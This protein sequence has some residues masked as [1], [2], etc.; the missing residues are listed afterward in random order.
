MKPR[1]LQIALWTLTTTLL[2]I[3]H[4][5]QSQT[6]FFIYQKSGHYGIAPW[7]RYNK[8]DGGFAGLS[9]V[10]FLNDDFR[11]LARVG[12]A[13]SLH[14]LRYQTGVE[15]IFPG[16]TT[17]WFI[18]ADYFHLSQTNDIQVIPDWQNSITAA[19]ARLDYYDYYDLHG[20]QVRIGM[21]RN[22]SIK[23]SLNAGYHRYET[24]KT[25]TQKSLVDW[26]GTKINGRRL[27]PPNPAVLK[28]EDVWMG[29]SLDY[30]P[31]PSPNAFINAWLV[32]ADYRFSEGIRRLA[33]TDFAY[34]QLQVDL[35]RQQRLFGK[36]RF[37]AQFRF[38]SY[39]GPIVFSDPVTHQVLPMTMFLYDVGGINTL[40]G[41]RYKEFRDG[42]RLWLVKLD[43]AFNGDFFPKTP[44]ARCW[45]LGWLFRK[46]DLAFFAD[47]GQLGYA[48]RKAFL[49]NPDGLS[50][51]QIH[52][53]A[54]V[55]VTMLPWIRMEL[56]FPLNPSESERRKQ[57]AFYFIFQLNI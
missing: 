22:G 25:E 52:Y 12:Y 15:K 13:F 36:Q 28:G 4:G 34:Q 18:M 43:Y 53:S 26:G 16:E 39:R 49:L 31:L 50:L 24:L 56:A 44:F 33:K 40:R 37:T 51:N 57:P 5:V 10:Y 41:Y 14:R 42:N 47:A 17:D 27:F 55:A 19:F 9:G 30:N 1:F 32:R 23:T 48:G 21:H 6:Q 54:G 45:G 46:T 7:I 3:P 2:L 8:V 11:W 20:G 35:R 29:L 38:L